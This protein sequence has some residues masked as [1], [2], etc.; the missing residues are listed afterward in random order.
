L[1][2]EWVTRVP[3]KQK[4]SQESTSVWIMRLGND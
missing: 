4:K 1:H 2:L 3:L